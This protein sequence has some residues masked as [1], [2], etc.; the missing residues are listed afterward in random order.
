MGKDETEVLQAVQG[1]VTRG[2]VEQE[3]PQYRISDVYA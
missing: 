3:G 1:L 2:I